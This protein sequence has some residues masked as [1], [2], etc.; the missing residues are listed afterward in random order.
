MYNIT[1]IICRKWTILVGWWYI[2]WIHVRVDSHL[3]FLLSNLSFPIQISWDRNNCIEQINNNTSMFLFEWSTR[4]AAVDGIQ[5]V[6]SLGE[7]I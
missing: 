3:I 4:I 5:R 1:M 2:R 7:F 6:G